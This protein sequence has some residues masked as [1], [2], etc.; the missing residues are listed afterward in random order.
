MRL[1][2]DHKVVTCS[3]LLDGVQYK[4]SPPYTGVNKIQDT[5]NM[6]DME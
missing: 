3:T 6:C 4:I 2:L 5:Y 1:E